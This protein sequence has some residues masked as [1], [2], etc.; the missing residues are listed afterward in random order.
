MAKG[1]GMTPGYRPGDNWDTCDRCDFERRS[2]ELR[3]EWTGLNVC[4]DTCWEPRHPQEFIRIR[5]ERIVPDS[6]GTSSD[7]TFAGTDING[8]RIGLPE[9]INFNTMRQQGTFSDWDVTPVFITVSDDGTKLFA[10]SQA[11]DT[12]YEYVFEKP[13]SVETLRSTGVSL[14]ITNETTTTRCI[15]VAGDGRYLY[16]GDA[17]TK[18]IY[19]YVMGTPNDLSTAAYTGNSGS[20]LT[21]ITALSL[22]SAFEVVDNGTKLFAGSATTD[23]VYAYT[24]STPYDIS[25]LAYTGDSYSYSSPVTYVGDQSTTIDGKFMYLIDVSNDNLDLLEFGTPFD[26]T[27]LSTSASNFSMTSYSLGTPTSIAVV[28]NTLFLMGTSGGSVLHSF[29]TASS[30]PAGTFNEDTL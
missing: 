10:L 3:R 15:S 11:T 4:A 14:P 7:T 8:N 2:S 1:H 6:P 9:S 24:M 18:A 21:E 5:P 19:Q 28:N 17:S 25:T 26:V 12:V 27:T 20:V 29:S 13:L 23:T 16:V 22:L 30:I